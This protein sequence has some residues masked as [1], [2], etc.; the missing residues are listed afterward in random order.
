MMSNKTKIAGLCTFF[1]FIVAFI[2]DFVSVFSG[3][4][5]LDS[6][7]SLK[8][9]LIA[10]I[11]FEIFASIALI[12]NSS[13][14]IYKLVKTEDSDVAFRRASD[15]VGG[16]GVYVAF[17]EFLGIYL[18]N[19]IA[20]QYHTTYKV[21]AILILIIVL[22]IISIIVGAMGSIKRLKVSPAVRSLLL[23]ISSVLMIVVSIILISQ[24]EQKALTIVEYVFILLALFA[25]IAFAYFYYE[26]QK[27]KLSTP[28]N[29]AKTEMPS[30]E[31]N[32]ENRQ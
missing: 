17:G 19:K 26:D 16:L 5:A 21:P 2:I 7:G 1:I 30:E 18:A 15:G 13:F 11:I 28:Q 8:G 9:T 4:D 27:V 25:S 31:D 23:V 3:F 6:A 29:V 14:G 20:E 22:T 24:G 10:I 32:Y 12:I